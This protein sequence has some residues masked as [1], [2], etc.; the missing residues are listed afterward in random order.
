MSDPQHA[1]GPVDQ[2]HGP[3]QF[4][5]R[6]DRDHFT[7]QRDMLTGSELRALPT[8]PIGPERDLFEVV[9]GGSDKKIEAQ[10]SVEMRNGLR[11]LTRACSDQPWS[12]R[13]RMKGGNQC[14]DGSAIISSVSAGIDGTSSPLPI[15]LTAASREWT[16]EEPGS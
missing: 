16:L 9:P 14:D 15:R 2:G 3:K 1:G 6:I 13:R 5:I 10:T 7:V 8:P 4:Q 11:F 12:L